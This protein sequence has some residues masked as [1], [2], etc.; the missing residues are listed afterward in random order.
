MITLLIII[1]ILTAFAWRKHLRNVKDKKIDISPFSQEPTLLTMFMV[2]GTGVSVI[3]FI[4]FCVK[5][6]P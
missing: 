5:Y 2:F 4:C 1:H 6:L 3:T